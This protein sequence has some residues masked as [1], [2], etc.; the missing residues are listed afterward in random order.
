MHLFEI[1]R[2]LD[3][4]SNR[5]VMAM[6]R[7]TDLLCSVPESVQAMCSSAFP[8]FVESPGVATIS[9]GPSRTELA[10]LG[11]TMNASN[12][13]EMDEILEVSTSCIRIKGLNKRYLAKSRLKAVNFWKEL[14]PGVQFSHVSNLD[15]A[16]TTG[17]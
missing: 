9:R 2:V 12:C 11:C 5:T 1:S 7:E 6:V 8:N 15:L 17:S 4:D 14:L 3:V 16:V 10:E 13:P